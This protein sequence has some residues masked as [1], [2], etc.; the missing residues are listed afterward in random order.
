MLELEKRKWT[1]M[2]VAAEFGEHPPAMAWH[3][4]TIWGKQ[5]FLVGGATGPGKCSGDVYV[6]SLENMWWS[7][8]KV[9]GKEF[10]PR[11]SHSAVLFGDRLLVL[12][13]DAAEKRFGMNEV[14]VLQLRSAMA[15]GDKSTELE[16]TVGGRP[17]KGQH[18]GKEDARRAGRGAAPSQIHEVRL[19]RG[20]ERYRPPC[21]RILPSQTRTQ[22]PATGL[23]PS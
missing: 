3:S 18:K 1:K 17:A 21:F 15:S 6:L 20:G 7:R 11:C 23:R 12:G 4:A 10:S 19:F 13:G 5:M 16:V 22:V 9:A 14:M 8:V 2:E